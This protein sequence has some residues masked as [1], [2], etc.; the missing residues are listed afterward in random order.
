MFFKRFVIFLPLSLPS[1]LSHFYDLFL[2]YFYSYIFRWEMWMLSMHMCTCECAHMN[3]V[4]AHTYTLYNQNQ[5]CVDPYRLL[6]I[7][8]VDIY[9]NIL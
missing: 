2:L 6:C 3:V 4:C 5:E 1:S 8:Y 7:V 9:C